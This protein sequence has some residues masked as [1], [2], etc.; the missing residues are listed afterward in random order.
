MKYRICAEA[1]EDKLAENV[2]ILD[3]RGITDFTQY[4]IIASGTS[5][6]QVQAIADSIQ[7]KM[8]EQKILPIGIE[9]YSEGKWVLMDYD[10]VVIHIFY[11]PVRA[12]YD[13]ER[14]WHDAK[15]VRRRKAAPKKLPTQVEGD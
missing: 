10:D 1:A 12:L 14:L 2:V 8:K 6:R 5:D 3:V 13:L 4:F 9:G 7:E 15:R 11:E